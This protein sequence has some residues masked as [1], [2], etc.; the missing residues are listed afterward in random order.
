MAY[1]W[2]GE[3]VE[4]QKGGRAN[5]RKGIMAKWRNGVMVGW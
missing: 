3:M 5:R 2:S 1:R 4:C